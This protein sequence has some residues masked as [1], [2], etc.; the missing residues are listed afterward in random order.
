MIF[1][2][3]SA[4]DKAAALDIQQR[5]LGYGYDPS[6]LFLVKKFTGHQR[7]RHSCNAAIGDG[8]TEGAVR[9]IVLVSGSHHFGDNHAKERWKVRG[10]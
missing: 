8:C 1:I 10:T 7:R 9:V 5:L 6:Q 3:H 4:K 2:S